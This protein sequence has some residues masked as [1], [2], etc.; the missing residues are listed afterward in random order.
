MVLKSI[1]VLFVLLVVL[2]VISYSNVGK[3]NLYY[4]EE[5]N[6]YIKSFPSRETTTI[7]FS[8]KKI[9]KFSDDL[10]YIKVHKGDD[11]Y[12]DFFFDGKDKTS[13]YSRNNSIVD[14]HLNVYRMKNVLFSDTTYYVHGGKG[15]YLLKPTY[16][17]IAVRICG[18][19]ERVSLKNREDVHY[20]V[21]K[22]IK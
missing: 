6:M 7:V 11:Y 12:T 22:P 18:S 19:S 17:G 20:T 2:F 14:T 13:I 16:T 10:D 3:E 9:N 1:L 4:I 21:I 8:D 15:R 5:V